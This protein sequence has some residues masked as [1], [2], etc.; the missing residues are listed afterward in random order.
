MSFNVRNVGFVQMGMKLQKATAF[1]CEHDFIVRFFGGTFK[2]GGKATKTS[3][4]RICS[5]PSTIGR[6]DAVVANAFGSSKLL[7]T[8]LVLELSVFLGG[9]SGSQ[10]YVWDNPLNK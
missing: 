6:S 5:G 4:T 1:S 9:Q 10:S 8:E 3:S 7:T 2:K